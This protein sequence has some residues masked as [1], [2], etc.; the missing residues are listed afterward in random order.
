MDGT[1][2][3]TPAVVRKKASLL[4]SSAIDRTRPPM[5]LPLPVRRLRHGTGLL[6]E[7]LTFAT[8]EDEHLGRLARHGLVGHDTI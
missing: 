2:R 1:T 6:Q 7:Q 4:L 5:P 8:R 3:K